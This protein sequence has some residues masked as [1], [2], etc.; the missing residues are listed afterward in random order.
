MLTDLGKFAAWW[1]LLGNTTSKLPL[2]DVLA[3]HAGGNE[4]RRYRCQAARGF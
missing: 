4:Q 1:L 2:A 3:R